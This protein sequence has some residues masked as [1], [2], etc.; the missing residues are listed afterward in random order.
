[1][2]SISD[3]GFPVRLEAPLSVHKAKS[4]HCPIKVEMRQLLVELELV[5]G[6]AAN[7]VSSRLRCSDP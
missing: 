4:F 2:R 6:L 5:G 3:A 7:Q 1:V